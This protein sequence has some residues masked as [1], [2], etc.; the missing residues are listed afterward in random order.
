MSFTAKIKNFIAP[1]ET[2][3][4][5]GLSEEESE[6]LSE[7]EQPQVAG[8]SKVASNANIVLFEPRQFDESQEIANHIKNRRACAIN[9]HRMPGEYRQRMIDFLT[10][11]IYA[12]DG[13]INKVGENVILCSPKNMPV[14]GEIN[15][16]EER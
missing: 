5:M 12:L 4:E 13:S 9:L 10:G 6:K 1:E 15:L 7:Y 11:V 16:G 8:A 2:D 14:G 3:D